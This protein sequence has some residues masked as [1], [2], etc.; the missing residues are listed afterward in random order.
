MLMSLC[1][2]P[3][4]L[5][6]LQSNIWYQLGCQFELRANPQ[7]LESHLQKLWTKFLQEMTHV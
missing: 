7:D 4:P 5:V 1:S 2:Q 6:F 3:G